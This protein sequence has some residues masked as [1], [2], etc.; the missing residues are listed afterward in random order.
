M[1]TVVYLHNGILCSKNTLSKYAISQ[2][3]LKIIMLSERMQTTKGHILHDSVNIEFII[4]KLI[5]SEKAE[6]LSLGVAEVGRRLQK[7]TNF[8]STYVHYLHCGTSFT[9][10]YEPKLE[11]Y[12]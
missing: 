4:C 11:L 2:M 5:Y 6:E 7:V 10:T 9:G 12:T 8:E 1:D 3:N